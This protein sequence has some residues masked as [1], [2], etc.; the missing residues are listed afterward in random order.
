MLATGAAATSLRCAVL[1]GGGGDSV[2]GQAGHAA[3]AGPTVR[4][5]QRSTTGF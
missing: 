4:E 1:A 3:N 2:P 5:W